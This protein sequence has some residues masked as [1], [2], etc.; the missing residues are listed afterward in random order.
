MSSIIFGLAFRKIVLKD[1]R[2]ILRKE[3]PVL[4]VI[5]MVTQKLF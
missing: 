2:K 5:E 4:V 1:F 3:L